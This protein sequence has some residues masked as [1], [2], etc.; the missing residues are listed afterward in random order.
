MV[1]AMVVDDE[2]PHGIVVTSCGHNHQPATATPSQLSEEPSHLQL[3]LHPVHLL[4]LLL[5]RP[6]LVPCH[7]A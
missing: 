5:L 6:L 7:Y 4:L 2:S 1:V 3:H